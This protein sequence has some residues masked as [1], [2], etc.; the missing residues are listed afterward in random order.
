MTEGDVYRFAAISLHVFS[1]HLVFLAAVLSS[2][3]LSL[4]VNLA[5]SVYVMQRSSSLLM[6][7]RSFCVLTPLT[8]VRFS[9]DTCHDFSLGVNTLVLKIN[10]SKFRVGNVFLTQS[11]TI[12]LFVYCILNLP[13]TF[14]DGSILDL[15]HLPV[16]CGLI[17]K[18]IS[19]M[20]VINH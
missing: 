11:I 17:S 6:T 13:I 7:W 5:N 4:F 19:L 2:L 9:N 10:I 1:L 20:Y 15:L 12:V 8:M 3:L 16:L 18:S 14:A